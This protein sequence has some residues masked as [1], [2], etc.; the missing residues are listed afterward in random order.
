MDA[1]FGQ[2]LHVTTRA[3]EVAGVAVIVIGMFFAAFNFLRAR[4]REGA[5]HEL[6]ATLGRA[7]L[8]GLELLVAADII[9]TVA[10][11]PTLDSLAVLAGIVLIR[12]FLSFSLEVEIEGKW[13]WQQA[14][15]SSGQSSGSSARTELVDR[16]H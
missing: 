3:I 13:P 7:I 11:E 5:Y 15:P 16:P 9:N 2:L 14:K 10:I 6:R 12:T 4:S 1:A 8:L